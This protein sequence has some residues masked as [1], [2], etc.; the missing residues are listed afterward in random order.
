[1]PACADTCHLPPNDTS[2]RPAPA[3]AANVAT[4]TDGGATAVPPGPIA[5]I[6][7][8]SGFVTW[9]AFAVCAVGTWT[10]SPTSFP[11]PTCA[12]S[13]P[14]EPAPRHVMTVGP[15]LV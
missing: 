6:T 13:W 12:K 1:M 14:A 3:N 8:P 7:D 9:M 5:Q 15:K 4:L 2:V 10:S 11:A